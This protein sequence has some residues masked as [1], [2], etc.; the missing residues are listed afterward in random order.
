MKGPLG[1]LTYTDRGEFT[2]FNP[3]S[4][5]S[6]VRSGI[7]HLGWAVQVDPIKPTLKAPG[8]DRL[9]LNYEELL[10]NF[11]FKFDLRRYS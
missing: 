8:T 4:G 11:G 3:A 2:V 6:S 1:N 5:E 7:S 10:S 9:K